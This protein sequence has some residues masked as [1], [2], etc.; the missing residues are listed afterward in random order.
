MGNKVAGA[1]ILS[2]IAASVCCITPVL[3]LVAGTSGMAASFA[4]L[5]PLRPFFI[6]LTALV[7]AFAWYQKLKP[8]KPEDCNCQ[9]SPKQNFMQTKAFL[10]IVTVFAALMLAFPSY[11]R[12]FYP[13]PQGRQATAARSNVQTVEITIKGMTCAGCEAHVDSEVNK[14][15]GILKVETSYAG[16]TTLVQFDKTRTDVKQIE[17]AVSATGYKVTAT[18]KK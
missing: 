10:S 8:V 1:G 4:W 14:L 16:G 17:K 3:A 2:A 9:I 12:V 13:Q 15:S 6:G 18:K 7:I 5:E 11:A